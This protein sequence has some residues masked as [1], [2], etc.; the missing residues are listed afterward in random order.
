MDHDII[1]IIGQCS[2]PPLSAATSEAAASLRCFLV[3]AALNLL[4]LGRSLLILSVSVI[5]TILGRL[6]PLRHTSASCP[7]RKLRKHAETRT[8][9]AQMFFV[10]THYMSK[11]A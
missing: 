7:V 11:H 5:E 6:Q 1:N 2:N 3:S 10:F 8:N 9:T 4:S